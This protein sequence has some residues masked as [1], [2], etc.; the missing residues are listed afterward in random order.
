MQMMTQ[1]LPNPYSRPINRRTALCLAVKAFWAVLT[2]APGQVV[3]PGLKVTYQIHTV[4]LEKRNFW[5][6]DV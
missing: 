4:A 2:K 6:C 5:G 1:P 3:W